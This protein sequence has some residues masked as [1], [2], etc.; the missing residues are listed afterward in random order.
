MYLLCPVYC[1]MGP[2]AAAAAARRREPAAQADRRRPDAGQHRPEGRRLKKLVTPTARRA[3]VGHL[4]QVRCR[5]GERAGCSARIGAPCAIGVGRGA[6]RQEC[7]NGCGRWRRSGRA[8]ATRRLH[9]LLK[10]ELGRINRQARPATVSA[11]GAGDPTTQAQAGGAYPRGM[12]PVAWQHGEAWAVDFMQDVLADG[13]R[14]RTLNVLDT[15]TRECLA[16]EV[17]TSLPGQRVVRLLDQLAPL[18]RRAEAD[19][20]GQWPRVHGPSRGRL[21]LPAPGSVGLHRSRQAHAERPS[22]EL[23][24]HIPGRVLERPL[25]PQLGGRTPDHH[26]LEG[27]IQ[28]RATA[29]RAWRPDP[30]GG[31]RQSPIGSESHIIRGHPMGLFPRDAQRAAVGQGRRRSKMRQGRH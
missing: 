24:R 26:G 22:R 10:R 16:I 12:R 1:I 2:T 20:P 31:G 28:Y 30:C 18:A 7:A 5:S 4:G 9:I 14:F 27:G 23:Q 25:V 17:D 29:Q 15:V 13:R 3:A 11:G 6:T 19:H 8:G 21:G